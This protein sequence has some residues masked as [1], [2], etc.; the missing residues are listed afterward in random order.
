MSAVAAIDR[1]FE[2]EKI[3]KDF[4]ILS[5]SMRGRPLV[6]LDSAASAQKP[7]AVLDAIADLYSNHY[8]N[9]HR[10]LYE[11][12]ETATRLHEQARAKVL[13]LLHAAQPR[14]IVFTRNA[15]EAINLVAQSFGRDQI[16]ADDEILITCMEHHANI[17]PWQLSARR[18]EPGCASPPSATPESYSRA[19]WRP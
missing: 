4:P 1:P 10:G 8:A 14:E 6:F 15:T 3:R 5:R 13:A 17:V 11:L 19:S 18:R 2:V 16:G 9:I 12:S 7:Q